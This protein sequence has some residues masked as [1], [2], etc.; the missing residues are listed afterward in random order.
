MFN[1][2]RDTYEQFPR[3][4][5]VVVGTH[6][7]DVIGNTLLNP[8]FALYVTQKFHVGMTQAGIIL[9]TNS[10]AGIVGSA[11]A[12]VVAVSCWN[13]SMLVYVRRV[14]G[15][16]ASAIGLKAKSSR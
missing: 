9:A 16:D 6:F 7:I 12:S 10:L 14:L 3:T 1:N 2:F 13:L 5:W 8:F 11:I 4:F 15:I